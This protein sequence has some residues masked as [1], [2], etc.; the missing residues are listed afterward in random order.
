MTTLLENQYYPPSGPLAVFF[1][2][3]DVQGCG[4][5]TKQDLHILVDQFCTHHP[6]SF[7]QKKLLFVMLSQGFARC[8]S[9]KGRLSWSD[10]MVYAPKLLLFFGPYIE[11]THVYTQQV[12]K[13]FQEISNNS[14]TLSSQR[15]IQHCES[16][17]PR[18]CPNKKLLS[19]F[20][21]YTLC[22]LCAG[23]NQVTE[24]MWCDTA[25]ALLFEVNAHR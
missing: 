2:S 13:R 5:I 15:L 9:Q 7:V 23:K 21:A 16:N 6:L 3:L 17:L 10:I 14:S 1:A 19:A 22:I 4:F 24:Q 8:A 18:M 25:L 12:S 20:L 11:D